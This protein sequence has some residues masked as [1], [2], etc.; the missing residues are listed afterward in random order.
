MLEEFVNYFSN[1]YLAVFVM[2]MIPAIESR[3]AIPFG[4]SYQIWH[5]DTLNAGWA[6]LLGFLGAIV[7]ALF[8]IWLFKKIKKHSCGFVVD[9]FSVKVGQ[10]N[11]RQ[12]V[13]IKCVL[14]ATF[15][16]IPLPLTG[17]YSGSIIAGLSKLKIWQGFISVV[18]G[19]VFSCVIVTL[20]CTIFN[21]SAFYIFVISI[22]I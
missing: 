14:L 15:V 2:S 11:E 22:A 20:L 12:S 9:K 6:A 13:L 5:N 16:A 21:N 17:V 18:V 8:V 4:M 1:P 7:P 10:L 3:V 19:E